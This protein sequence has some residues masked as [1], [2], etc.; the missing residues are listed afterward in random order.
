LSIGGFSGSISRINTPGSGAS[1]ESHHVPLVD[2]ANECSLRGTAC[3]LQSWQ[4]SASDVSSDRR[5]QGEDGKNNYS[6][7]YS[8]LQTHLRQSKEFQSEDE[9]LWM[10]QKEIDWRCLVQ[11]RQAMH[12]QSDSKH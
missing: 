1:V 9:I 12:L 7:L 8:G 11:R 2:E 6:K 10:H 3:S 4:V 5:E